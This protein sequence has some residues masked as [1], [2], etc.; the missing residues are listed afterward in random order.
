MAFVLP[1]SVASGLATA[2]S[3][4]LQALPGL[5]VL[6]VGFTTI[7]LLEH[8]PTKWEKTKSVIKDVGEVLSVLTALGAFV[9]AVTGKKE[10]KQSMTEEQ[11]TSVIE[12]R[13]KEML[14]QKMEFDR[15]VDSAVAA[16]KQ[17]VEAAMNQLTSLVE[18]E[19]AAMDRRIADAVQEA[20]DR[21]QAGVEAKEALDD[22]GDPDPY[23]KGTPAKITKRPVLRKAAG[24]K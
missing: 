21:H 4:G 3:V 1:P 19:R 16:E 5:A 11:L 12:T 9:A 23:L 18:Q 22:L 2:G 6:G 7:K 13:A 8:R 10:G 24:S 20:L 17:S 15:R 14:A